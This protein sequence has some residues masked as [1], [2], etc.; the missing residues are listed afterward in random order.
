MNSSL[1]QT[2]L[3][4][5]CQA[6]SNVH[7]NKH[8]WLLFSLDYFCAVCL[9]EY[10]WNLWLLNPTKVLP[11]AVA[12]GGDGAETPAVC[13]VPPVCAFG[14][15]GGLCVAVAAW[16]RLTDR[17][18]QDGC[19]KFLTPTGLPWEHLAGRAGPVAVHIP[20]EASWEDKIKPNAQLC[21]FS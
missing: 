10:F 5:N 9:H 19:R 11:G 12:V 2:N 17:P 1:W 3:F 14:P 15:P 21:Y 6:T 8:A 4:C 18:H 20:S 16:P 13:C 7:N